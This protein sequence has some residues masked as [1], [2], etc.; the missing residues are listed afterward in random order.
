MKYRLALDLGTT[1]LGWAVF[2]LDD[3][4][5]PNAIV[6]AGV[7]IFSDGRHPKDGSSLAVQRREARAMRR[8]RDRLL[9]RKAR[10]MRKLVEYGFFP[11]DPVQRKN[12]ER[13]HPDPYALRAKGLDQALTPGEF[14]R[15]LFHLN[16]RR[17]FKSNRRTDKA[18]KESGALKT[19]ISTLRANMKELGLRT[20]GEYLHRR[21]LNGETARLRDKG[22]GAVTSKKSYEFYIDRQMVEDEFDRLW[23]VQAGFNPA[24][25]ND[26]AREDLRDTLL[27]Q[28]DLRPVKPGRCTLMPEKERAPLAL[29]ST[30]RFRLYQEV[31][32]LRILDENLN[33]QVLTLAQ[34]DKI[35]EELE[36]HNKRSFDQIRRLLALSGASRFNLEDAKRTELKGN[37][38]NVILARKEHF[39]P[40]WFDFDEAQQDEIVEML[41]TEESEGVLVEWLM[42]HTGVDQARAQAISEATLPAGFGSLCLPALQ[43]IIPALKKSVITYSEAVREAGFQHHSKLDFPYTPDEVEDW[44]D[45]ATGEI[46][47]VFKQLPYYGKALQRH[48][49]FGSGRVQD[50]EEKRYGKIANPTVHIGLNQVRRVVNTLIQRY[51]RPTEVVV[52]LARDLKESREQRLETQRQQAQNQK[53]NERIR[54]DI[55]AARRCS[56]HDVRGWEI[57]KWILWEELSDKCCE[58]RCPYSGEQISVAMLLSDQVEIEHILPF[59]RTLDDSKNNK[60]VSL[61]AANRIKKNRTPWEA[62]AD[63]E[64]QGWKYED[65]LSRAKHMP[66]LQKR[67]RFAQDAYEKWLG[68]TKDFLA[69]ALNDTR[70]LSRV[71]KAYLSLVCPGSGVR[72]IPG[73]MTAILRRHLGLNDIVKDNNGQ[74]NRCDHRHHAIDACV[75]GITDQSMLQQFAN[76]NKRAKDEGLERLVQDF[77]PPWPTYWAHVQRAIDN[78]WVS[79]RPD[80]GYQGGMMEETAHG[81]GKNGAIRQR[82]GKREIQN[83]IRISEPGQRERHGVD[84]DGN[85]LPYKGY[86]GGSNYCL[87]IFKNEKGNWAGEVISTFQAYQI[88]RKEGEARLRD[89]HFAQNG[90]PLVM[91]L[92]RNDVVCLGG[93]NK[94]GA[95][96]QVLRVV[97]I[98]LTG[99]FFMAPLHEGNVDARNRDKN[100]P[101]KYVS[102]MPGSLINAKARLAT[103]SAIGELKDPGFMD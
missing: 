33:E 23:E 87:E 66:N 28:R 42:T 58:R 98:G 73:R 4:L 64:R 55:A 59:S 56:E 75:I 80:H 47:P 31:N 24:L 54:K 53:R 6:R 39:G 49:A 94:D 41:C 79:H 69:R 45:P 48:V 93:G 72:V 32:N 51:G 37:A 12:L 103:V 13:R 90:K 101:F 27:H 38:T 82:E 76:A 81:I 68:D 97:K 7:R 84:A 36:R 19:A 95:G 44:I 5:R 9:K 22:D 83:L 85:P 89:K 3:A 92:M 21:I 60:T 88:A 11:E 18:E 30:Q 102:K 40:G 71:A 70:H 100:D 78:I 1:S 61:R 91:R 62:K 96:R 34:R 99:Q 43:R 50:P 74:K 10:M 16:Q 63:F 20:V 46:K 14:A 65:I 29:P 52:E 26:N 25:Y 86:V 15:A 35:V 57:E 8:R 2:R 77:Q 67:Q 17:G